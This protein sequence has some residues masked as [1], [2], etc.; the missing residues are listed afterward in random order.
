MYSGGSFSRHEEGSRAE[1]ARKLD[2]RVGS[3][4]GLQVVMAAA[5]AAAAAVAGGMCESRQNT[6]AGKLPGS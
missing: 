3:V 2:I 5:A 1:A 4:G 6:P